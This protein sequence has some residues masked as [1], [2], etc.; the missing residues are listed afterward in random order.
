MTTKPSRY[1]DIQSNKG[2]DDPTYPETKKSKKWCCFS[3]TF[4][5]GFLSIFLILTAGAALGV[6]LYY[7]QQNQNSINNLETTNSIFAAQIAV[8]Q[9]QVAVLSA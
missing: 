8:L 7:N 4:W 9:A 3:S 2:E 6:E 5:F 1:L